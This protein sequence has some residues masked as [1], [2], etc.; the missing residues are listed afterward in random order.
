MVGILTYYHISNYGANFQAFALQHTILEMGKEV[1]IIK[2]ESSVI[3]KRAIRRLFFKIKKEKHILLKGLIL[4]NSVR[5]HFDFK[6]FR[7]KYIYIKKLDNNINKIIVGSDQV[8]NTDINGGDLCY[9]VNFYQGKKYS[10]AASFGYEKV[11]EKYV[12]GIKLLLDKFIYISVREEKGRSILSEQFGLLSEIVLDPI[13]FLTQED[14]RKTFKLYNN[15]KREYLLIYIIGNISC[16]LRKYIINNYNYLTCINYNN[17]YVSDKL[18]KNK[19]CSIPSKW[20]SYIL[21]SEVNVTNSYHGVIF[22]ILF[23]KKFILYYTTKQHFLSRLWG[24]FNLLEIKGNT[25]D[26]NE[27]EKLFIPDLNYDI[28][29]RKILPLKRKSKEYL[30]KIIEE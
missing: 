1:V 6:Q 19:N 28:I 17:C 25:I 10:Y 13:F 9:F 22:S 16:D 30:S 2:Y 20:L 11:P 5:T 27:E 3:T 12:D 15:E 29:N 21:Y 7:K 24:I 14:W 4:F 8:W 23:N 26:L 18:I